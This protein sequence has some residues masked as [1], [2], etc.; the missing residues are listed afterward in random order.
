MIMKYI[1]KAKLFSCS[2]DDAPKVSDM[3]GPKEL[4]RKATQSKG[5]TLKRMSGKNTLKTAKTERQVKEEK[6][7]KQVAAA[8]KKIDGLSS[9]M[10]ACQALVK[11]NCTKPRIGKG[12]TIANAIKTILCQCLGECPKSLTKKET[13]LKEKRLI[14]SSSSKWQPLPS[15]IADSVKVCSLEFA[16]VL[17]K[18]KAM[19]GLDYI[20][21]IEADLVTTLNHMKGLKH[22]VIC[23][24]KYQFTPDSFKEHTRNQRSNKQTQTVHHLKTGREILSAERFDKQACIT[25]REGK[26]LITTYLAKNVD[27]LCLKEDILLDI[28]SE[29]YIENCSCVLLDK[30]CDCT[31]KFAVPIRCSFKESGMIH[32]EKLG[33]MQRK[34]EAEMA[35]VDWLARCEQEDDLQPGDSVVSIVTSGDID[36]VVIHMFYISQHW[37]RIDGKFPNPV[38]VILQKP[39]GSTIYNI[40]GMIEV[41]EKQYPNDSFIGAKLSM[42]LCIGG[43]DFIPKMNWFSHDKICQLYFKEEKFR[44]TMFNVSTNGITLEITMYIELVKCLYFKNTMG[45]PNTMTFEEVRKA[46]IKKK[47][48][49]SDSLATDMHNTNDPDR[50]MPPKGALERMGNLIQLQIDYLSTAGYSSAPLPNFLAS[51]CLKVTSTGEVEYDFGEDSYLTSSSLSEITMSTSL[52]TPKKGRKRLSVD[53][54]QKGRRKKMPLKSSTPLKSLA[55]GDL[56]E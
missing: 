18:S 3:Q 44:N 20:K 42:V 1:A 53:T 52:H 16:G 19:S 27:K 34:G 46:T 24:E 15:S 2:S 33:M 36:A 30:K 47:K 49:T 56:H 50:W 21:L 45:D 48:K 54:P 26:T 32:C 23:E 6:R 41:L 13:I 51:N 9:D 31:E 8:V 11:P 7:K 17:F 28:D 22:L 12:T 29:L 4:V 5:T 14:L 55:K 38:Y 25:S 39:S 40:T 43:N 37:P 35:Q 10:N